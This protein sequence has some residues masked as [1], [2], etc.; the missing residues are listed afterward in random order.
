MKKLL[1]ITAK[2]V[3]ALAYTYGWTEEVTNDKGIITPNPQ[4]KGEKAE[5]VILG[6]IHEVEV[7]RCCQEERIDMDAAV[8]SRKSVMVKATFTV[9]PTLQ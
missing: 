3:D 6:F 5:S 7:A 4:S 8:E 9:S 2:Q 1:T